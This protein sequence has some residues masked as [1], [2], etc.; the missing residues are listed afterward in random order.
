MNHHT[1][2]PAIQKLCQVL[3][4]ELGILLNDIEFTAN[5]SSNNISTTNNSTASINQ[6]AQII[7]EDFKHFNEY[8]QANLTIFSENLCQS[9]TNIIK[10]LNEETVNDQI[11]HTF[12]IKKILLICRF[13]NSLTNHCPNL[14]LC[15]NDLNRHLITHRQLNSKTSSSNDLLGP[16]LSNLIKKKAVSDQK[17]ND[18]NQFSLENILTKLIT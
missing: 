3:D 13:T 17:A 9:I 10:E 16:Q 15:F 2:T 12:N 14:K 5:I 11:T 7:N 1:I 4:D 8:L 6:I 18:L